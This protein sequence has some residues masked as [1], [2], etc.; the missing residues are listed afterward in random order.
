MAQEKEYYAFISYAREDEKL[1]KW[2]AH[3]LENYKL[4]LTLNGKKL[5][6]NLRKTFRDVDELS[7]GNLPEQIYNALS[8]SE[9]LIVVCS[10]HAAKSK[11]VNKEIEDYIKIKGGKSN[12]IFP[13]VIEGTP[14]SKNV[15]TECF[16]P[17]LRDLPKEEERL[18]GNINEQGGRN[19]AIVKVVAGMLGVSFDSLWHRHEKDMKRKRNLI[20][21][22][23]TTFAIAALGIALWMWQLNSQISLTNN[24]L[25]NENIRIASRDVLYL[26]EKGQY[27]DA[28]HQVESI[29][30]LWNY[31]SR[32]KVPE[33]EKA[34]RALYRYQ[35]KDGIAKI[36][37]L[38]LSD[39]QVF[40]SADS[41]YLYIRDLNEGSERIVSY[42]ITSGD[43]AKQIFPLEGQKINFAIQEYNHG[44]V[45]CENERFSTFGV[46][47]DTY[48]YNQ[49]N[50]KT[51]ME[52][53]GYYHGKILDKDKL[54]FLH[55]DTLSLKTDLEVVQANNG[56]TIQKWSSPSIYSFDTAFLSNDSLTVIGEDRVIVYNVRDG[57]KL[58]ELDYRNERMEMGYVLHGNSNI[59]N[60]TKQ[61]A[62]SSEYGL[63]LFS[64]EKQKCTILNKSENF[65]YV[66]FNPSGTMLA[67]VKN[68][69]GY[70]KDSILVYVTGLEYPWFSI[71]GDDFEE[72][73]F[74]N[75]NIFVEGSQHRL[76][77]YWYYA[78]FSANQLYSPS[79]NYYVNTYKDAGI[80][81]EIY[82]DSTEDVISQ[83]KS[84]KDRIT[85]IY[86]FSPQDTYLLYSTTKNPLILYHIKEGNN[87]VIPIL[88][89][90][91]KH[92]TWNQYISDDES[93]LLCIARSY[94]YDYIVLYNIKKDTEKI[95][96]FIYDVKIT[97]ES[98]QKPK[99][100]L[101]ANGSKMAL[102]DGTRINVFGID[103]L[104][105]MPKDFVI[106]DEVNCSVRDLC[107]SKGDSQL[108][109]ASYSDGTIR[110]WDAFSGEQLYNT[111]HSETSG[112]LILD[113]SDDSQYLV[114]TNAL[115]DE[116]WEYLVWHI[117]SGTLVDKE[118]NAWSWWA[119]SLY[120]KHLL[121]PSFRARFAKNTN[122]IIVN[123]HN[124]LGLSRKFSFP[125][126]DE[127]IE[128]Y[129]RSHD[130]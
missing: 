128:L 60:S 63:R 27:T 59:N 34:L 36:Y 114:G 104:S 12:R 61:F 20:L 116:N 42:A 83:I 127:L 92:H 119:K 2:L 86:G 98:H 46:V 99:Y 32:Q 109:A 105:N 19:A 126:F 123:D 113:I 41:N 71:E 9:N 120:S 28:K 54:L 118:T 37:S 49:E 91:I 68:G 35:W 24:K 8:T 5:P 87:F 93:K 16:P 72:I 77:V 29:I 129:S 78:D 40:L 23:I 102:Y 100:A 18:G 76:N 88:W 106:K 75:D 70:E 89:E 64:T 17:A 13:F 74:A 55:Y 110:F 58:Y 67:A 6:P 95:I 103:S 22:G 26:L 96:D 84:S 122:E 21:L 38:P 125:S 14:Y 80:S 33:M 1:A 10:P 115:G 79:G 130:K 30:D 51:M 101:N 121:K 117:P 94:N 4:P 25:V 31:G 85:N 62:K 73:Y 111:I 65:S 44:M 50:G 15:D 48:V 45:L 107:F 52:K 112:N 3:E 97:Y 69:R 7:S 81:I 82:N 53:K 56:Q 108:L 43:S 39:K 47:R 66:A 90:D 57:K 124:L 11:W